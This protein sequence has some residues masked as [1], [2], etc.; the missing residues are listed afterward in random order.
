MEQRG[1]DHRRRE[2]RRAA[3]SESA[4]TAVS[5]AVLRTRSRRRRYCIWSEAIMDIGSEDI[6]LAGNR[7]KSAGPEATVRLVSAQRTVTVDNVL[8]N[9]M[10]HNY[11][12]PRP[13]GPELRGAQRAR[14]H[15]RDD[16]HRGRRPDSA[17]R[18]SKAT[19]F[20]TRRPTCFIPSG[21]GS[22]RCTCATTSPTRTCGSASVR[23]GSQPGATAATASCPIARP[24]ARARGS[25]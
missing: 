9:S 19:P 6:L 1:R 14:Q 22:R 10:K 18:G 8:E 13:L 24:R 5:V 7:F 15:R 16:R 12:H 20:I 11:P 2:D 23:F 3:R 17:A 4:S 25:R 21:A